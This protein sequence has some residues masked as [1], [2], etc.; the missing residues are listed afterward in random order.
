MNILG[1]IFAL[2]AGVFFGIIGVVKLLDRWTNLSG[3][4]DFGL[5]KSFIK[6]IEII[7]VKQ[8]KFILRKQLGKYY[9]SLLIYGFL[10][11]LPNIS[12][13]PNFLCFFIKLIPSR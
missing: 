2:L 12:K 3:K 9:N 13:L 8:K 10:R 6:Q 4:I 5:N 1:I 7:F 11:Y